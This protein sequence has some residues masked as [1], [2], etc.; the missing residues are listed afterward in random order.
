MN[1]DALAFGAHPDD[2]ELSCSG[3]LIWL[4]KNGYRT[5]IITL[6]EAELG[7]QGSPEI[8]RKEFD[9]ASEIM[10]T[11]YHKALDIPDGSVRST[12]VNRSR[13]IKVIREWRPKIIFVPY[14]ETRHPDHAHC[15][16]LCREAAYLSGLSKIDSGQEPFRPYKVIYYMELYDFVPSFIIDISTTFEKK[17]QA[18]KAYTSQFLNSKTPKGKTF[19]N[20]PEFLQLIE[21]RAKYFGSKIGVQYGEPFLVREPMKLQ[22]PVAH[23]AGYALAGLL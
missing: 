16:E 1:L 10:G 4:A 19:I 17:M 23:F 21:T 2:V 8:R 3:T 9:R 12:S 14:W 5:G 22:D 6:T 18:I 13:V 20:Q 11:S 7:S 15:C